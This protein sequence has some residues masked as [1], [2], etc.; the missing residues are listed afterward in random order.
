M[1]RIF[2]SVQIFLKSYRLCPG[3]HVHG[4]PECRSYFVE[5]VNTRVGVKYENILITKE[6]D[7]D[8]NAYVRELTD[9]HHS[10]RSTHLSNQLV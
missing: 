6:H 4:W 7:T 10:P 9:V 8:I 1:V 3:T 2:S 5:G